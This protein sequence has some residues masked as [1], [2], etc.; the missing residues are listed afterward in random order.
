MSYE[1]RITAAVYTSPSGL[2][3]TGIFE[4]VSKEIV[5]KTT[6]FNF[7]DVDGTFIQDLGKQGRRYPMRWIF[8]GEDYDRV[9]ELF[10]SALEEKGP[11]ILQHPLYG[12]FDVVPFGSIKRR[13]D[14]VN[15]ANQAVYDI[16]FFETIKII[17]PIS[18]LSAAN[19][20]NSGFSA[21]S[22]ALIDS[23][24]QSLSIDGATEI[25]GYIASAKSGL[26]KVKKAMAKIAATTATIERAFNDI[27]DLADETIT[28]LIGGPLLIASQMIA[29]SRLPSQAASS[30]QAKLDA[31]GN[32]L[33]SMI[34]G[35]GNQ[36]FQSCG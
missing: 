23:Y 1:D 31:Y 36:F 6:A 33:N 34:N 26:R 14:L 5:K 24:N 25:T 2:E 12:T 7:P 4:D 9:A 13:D 3:F 18:D 30:I 35:P 29:L 20:M 22:Q 17:F 19:A 8:W 16:T 27:A 15:A 32:L 10:D 11:G 21:Y 28:T